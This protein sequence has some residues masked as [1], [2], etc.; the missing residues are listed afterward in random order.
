MNQA[1]NKGAIIM[2]WADDLAGH[3]EAEGMLTRT[4]LT[5]A[6]SGAAEQLGQWMRE[7]GMSVRRDAAGNVFG[8]PGAPPSASTYIRIDEVPPRVVFATAQDPSDPERIEAT[9]DD[10]GDDGA[11]YHGNDQEYQP[12][13]VLLHECSFRRTPSSTNRRWSG[14]GHDAPPC[15]PS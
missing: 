2:R 14:R 5:A 7:A 11:D 12:D 4:Y 9:V 1:S 8:G 6:H 3:S 10:S 15:S 13:L